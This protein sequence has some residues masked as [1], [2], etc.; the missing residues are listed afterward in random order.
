VKQCSKCGVE[1]PLD[2]FYSGRAVCK[3]CKR[4]YQRGY[5]IKNREYC[6]E[7]W[8]EYRSTN[9]E[10]VSKSLQKY[11]NRNR[12]TR[13]ANM[14]QRR[15]DHPEKVKAEDLVKRARRS[16]AEGK[17]TAEQWRARL[18][19]HGV[20]TCYYCK[21]H[22]DEIHC[23]HRIPLSRGGTNWPANLVPACPTCNLSKGTK[24]E[25]EFLDIAQS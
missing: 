17:C 1:K 20:N 15:K 11:H 5:Y 14:R 13:N 19:Y 25:K 21:C 6:I 9:R 10:A 12:D 16:S 3:A 18:L 2:E 22:T 7:W 4:A 8:R 23:E 24:T